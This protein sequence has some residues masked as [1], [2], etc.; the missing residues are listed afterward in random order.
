M[1][2]AELRAKMWFAANQSML[3]QRLSLNGAEGEL[4]DGKRDIYNAAGYPKLLDYK[5]H[6]KPMYERGGIATRVVNAPADESWRRLPMIYEG[7][8][9]ETGKTDSDFC[10]KWNEI[11]KH[12][13]KRGLY[14]YLHRLDRVSGIGR[15]GVLYFGLAGDVDL[16][17]PA[18]GTA[19]LRYVTVLEEDSVSFGEINR[20]KN[21]PRFGMPE[22]YKITVDN[23]FGIGD[24]ADSS[25]VMTTLEVHHSRVLHVAED[26]TTNDLFGTP[27]LKAG[28][29]YL[30]NLMKILAGSGEAAWKL[31]DSGNLFTTADNYEL[32]RPGTEE[33]KK[34]EEQVENHWNGLSR[35]LLAEGLTTMPMG[36]SVTDPTGL[37]NNNVAMLSATIDMPQRILMGSER[38]ELASSQDSKD[39]LESIEERQQ[40]H[41]EPMILRPVVENFIAW[42]ILPQPKDGFGF[43]WEKLVKPDRAEGANAASSMA[44]ALNSMGI[45][46]E[47]EEFVRVYAPDIDASKVTKK[48][49]PQPMAVGSPADRQ[50]KAAKEMA[51]NIAQALWG[52][53]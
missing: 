9:A 12:F 46:V 40:N 19:D 10:N 21:D 51:A 38:G 17:M 22:T 5:R 47:P 1:T 43:K 29:N 15:F 23:A 37:I 30:I 3:M 6:Y 45:E 31:M 50:K 34:L 20:D 27:R 28:Y 35:G 8:N 53:Y 13:N 2:D 49:L 42:G 44:S 25:A 7:K 33:R 14:H 16:K 36:G 41:V 4:M 18:T 52:E 26:A 24:G 11:A 32:P 39:W 48:E